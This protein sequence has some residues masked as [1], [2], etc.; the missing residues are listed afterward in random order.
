MNCSRHILR[1]K[2]HME[3]LGE[4][5]HFFLYYTVEIHTTHDP[6]VSE[7][8]IVFLREIIFSF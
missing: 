6:I 4:M 5:K 2:K 1:E 8:P 3:I 7:D